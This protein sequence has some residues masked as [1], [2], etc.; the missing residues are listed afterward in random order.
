VDEKIECIDGILKIG[1]TSYSNEAVSAHCMSCPLPS[2]ILADH[3][4]IA[5]SA[6]P[7]KNMTLFGGIVSTSRSD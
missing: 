3:D 2:P 1:K 7:G 6:R 4:Q 5:T